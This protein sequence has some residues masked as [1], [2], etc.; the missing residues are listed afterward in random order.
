MG[1]CL[2]NH[3][4]AP[5]SGHQN[6]AAML[7]AQC[8]GQARALH[9]SEPAGPIAPIHH[10]PPAPCMLRWIRGRPLY[11]VTIHARY[12]PAHL[13]S[14][15]CQPMSH[16]LT[17]VHT[18]FQTS[19]DLE[20]GREGGRWTCGPW[21]CKSDGTQGVSD[22]IRIEIWGEGR[23][24]ATIIIHHIYKIKKVFNIISYTHQNFSYF[25]SYS[26]FLLFYSILFYKVS[27]FCQCLS[28]G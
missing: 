1:S 24:I 14:L 13:C 27:T 7:G 10:P 28:L 18:H 23:R 22:W 15:R 4:T 21:S 8:V 12:P 6:T 20:E 17:T 25:F 16:T 3:S 26:V 5:G 19:W 2:T 11:I 9:E